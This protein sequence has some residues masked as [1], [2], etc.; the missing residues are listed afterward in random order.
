[1][2]P[3]YP[4]DGVD[5]DFSRYAHRPLGGR[6]VIVNRIMEDYMKPR[7]VRASTYLLKFNVDT[8]L[9]FNPVKSQDRRLGLDMQ[10]L[11]QLLETEWDVLHTIRATPWLR[12]SLE[13]DL[14]DTALR[15]P[16]LQEMILAL[17]QR[18]LLKYC[19]HFY[20]EPRP[21]PPRGWKKDMVG[22]L[23]QSQTVAAVHYRRFLFSGDS[24]LPLNGPMNHKLSIDPCF[25]TLPQVNAS[26]F[27]RKSLRK[28]KAGGRDYVHVSLNDSDIVYRGRPRRPHS[29][30]PHGSWFTAMLPWNCDTA[31]RA[32][33][34]IH[35]PIRPLSELDKLS[36]RRSLSRTHI[37]AMFT[38]KPQ[39]ILEDSASRPSPPQ[40]KHPCT[41]CYRYTHHT[42]DCP[43][44]CG[45]CNS[46]EHKARNCAVKPVNRCKCR[47]FPQ[48]HTA[49]NCFVPCSRRC[50]SPY[51]QCHF[52][53][54]SAMLCS[55]RCCMCGIKG[56]TGRKCSLKR[57][58]C[59]GQH[60]TQDCRWKVE[61]PVKTCDRYLCSLHCKECG[62]G[63]Q[64]GGN[65]VG[66][67]CQSCLKNA[68]PVSAKAE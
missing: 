11:R 56:H 4:L 13:S 24:Q 39:W 30:P 58:P 44:N 65:F 55:S 33:Y 32:Y 40:I 10:V 12:W 43:S 47:P 68:T 8:N 21:V 57:C 49:I 14:A 15:W 64:P 18:H 9:N 35:S 53:H 37:R 51:P 41:N 38:D 7:R 20:L 28:S 1:M 29:V 17:V 5:L 50:G 2:T 61:C 63:N 46:D 3:H 66:R 45:Y 31:G 36:R 26:Q 16:T 42:R 54:K 22:H 60:L 48:Y 19:H 52:K 34:T 62:R 27:L 23:K 25:V 59:G 67:T 6:D